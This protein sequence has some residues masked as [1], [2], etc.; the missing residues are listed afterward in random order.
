MLGSVFHIDKKIIVLF[1][2]SLFIYII[3]PD[4][5]YVEFCTLSW[6]MVFAFFSR[7][8]D[9]RTQF[10][11]HIIL[12]E[13]VNRHWG[14]SVATTPPVSG[15]EAFHQSQGRS[16]PALECT[17]SGPGPFVS[18]ILWPV[19][20][21]YSSGEKWRDG[22]PMCT[23]GYTERGHQNKDKYLMIKFW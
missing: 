3:I 10:V 22:P 17:W 4:Y 13:A 7:R 12:Q 16:W 21:I 18:R 9:F 6:F 15:G 2:I 19:M 14:T 1:L 20:M 8:S 11:H 5:I 23:P